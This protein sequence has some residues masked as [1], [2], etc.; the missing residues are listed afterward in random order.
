VLSQ[1]ADQLWRARRA[2][3]ILSTA[4]VRRLACDAQIA[5]VLTGPGGSVLDLGR[6]ARTAS[7]PVAGPAPARRRVH[8]AQL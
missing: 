8:L 7:R 3:G 4:D 2:G 6:T 5:R 1:I